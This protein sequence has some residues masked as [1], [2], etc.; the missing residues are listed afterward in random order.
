MQVLTSGIV[1]ITKR[2]RNRQVTS[3]AHGCLATTH[4]RGPIEVTVATSR[5][6][7]TI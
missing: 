7:W 6:S 1:S 3:R 2:E 4:V 5:Y